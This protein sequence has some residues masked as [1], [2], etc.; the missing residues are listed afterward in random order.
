MRCKFP[1]LF[2]MMTA[3]VLL[4]GV[5]AL[6]APAHA[7]GAAALGGVGESQ[8]V[9]VRAK[10][11]AVNLKTREV[12]L[13]KPTGEVFT[14]HA[15]DAVK[16]LAEIKPGQTVIAHYYTSVAY[17]LS[18]G[19]AD[20]PE[21]TAAVAAAR[22]EKTEL[23]GG[24]VATRTVVTGTVVG[25]DMAAHQLQLVNPTGGRIVTVDVQDPQRQ[26]DMAMVN[27]GDR[28]TIVMT[29]ALAIGI[30]RAK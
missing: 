26:K 9:T 5:P 19:G 22:A 25:I 23:P 29:E 30:E 8:V 4:I 28:L 21:N 1:H 24:V 18:K 2:G 7:Q 3:G 17:V 20:T 10:V 15:G 12:T 13:V 16:R 11:K 14:V 6:T 27:V